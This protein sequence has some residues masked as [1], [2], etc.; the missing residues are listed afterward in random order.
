MEAENYGS[1]KIAEKQRKERRAKQIDVKKF[2]IEFS[3]IFKEKYAYGTAGQ[4]GQQIDS[5][6]IDDFNLTSFHTR[7]NPAR[8][9]AHRFR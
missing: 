4:S 8:H 9:P 7:S 5:N 6:G 1:Q 2:R 3:D